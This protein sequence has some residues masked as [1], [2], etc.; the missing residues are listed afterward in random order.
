MAIRLAWHASGTFDKAD[1][2]GGSDGA[3][4]RFEPESTDGANAGLGIMRDLLKPVKSAFPDVSTAD[5]WALAGAAACSFVG[6]PQVPVSRG[7]TDQGADG[8]PENGRLPDAALGAQHLRDVFYRQ[9]FNDREIVALSGAHTLGRCHVSRSGFDGPWTSNPLKFD[10]EYFV[11]LLEKKWHTREWDGNE[12]YEDEKGELMMLP[13]DIALTTDPAFRPVVEE[14][15]KDEALFRREFAAAFAKLL[16]NGC[17]AGGASPPKPPAGG[18]VADIATRRFAENAMHGSLYA[19][20]KHADAGADVA[21]AEPDTG[22]T[23]LHKAAF[24]G[25]HDIVSYLVGEKG[26]SPDAVDSAGDTALHDAARFGHAD[27]IKAL[28]AGGASVSATNAAGQTPMDVAR[29][30]DQE[31]A[32]AGAGLTGGSAGGAVGGGM[33]PVLMERVITNLLDQIEAK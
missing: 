32:A 2:S 24:W 31:A 9:G 21:V 6:G 18:A 5:I 16:A 4:M 19:C 27:V 28:L 11:N 33:P 14:Y 10:N 20:R 13:T 23:P 22:R 3:T 12:Q 15:A 1:G 26:I 25:H 8:C 29:V 30:F 17:P 7:R